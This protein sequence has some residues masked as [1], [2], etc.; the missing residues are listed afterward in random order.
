MD[1]EGKVLLG[2]DKLDT[3]TKQGRSKIK[4]YLN[5]EKARAQRVLAGSKKEGESDKYMVILRA[6]RESNY[7]D[8]F[9]VLQL[10]EEAGYRRWQLRV[11]SKVQGNS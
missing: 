11:Q 1:K 10:C 8:V 3:R 9:H 4:S 5:K 2:G 6:H 7:E